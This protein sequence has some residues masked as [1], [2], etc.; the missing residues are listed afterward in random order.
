M[1]LV[2]L[3]VRLGLAIVFVIAGVAKLVDRPGSRQS[4]QAF[5]VP[6]RL[7]PAGA[8]ALPVLEIAFALGLLPAS[9]A[10][11][12]SLGMLA[13][14]VGFIGGIAYNL[15]RGRRPDCHCFGQL[16][17]KPIGNDTLVRNGLLAALAAVV[18]LAGP[19]GSGPSAVAW[20]LDL[21]V[22]T[23]L[24]G[25]AVA[26]LTV[27]CAVEAWFLLQLFQQHGR[28]LKRLETAGLSEPGA[29]PLPAA[30]EAGLPINAPAPTLAL[31]AL[32][33]EVTGLTELLTDHRPAVLLFVDPGCRPCL[34]LLPEAADWRQRYADRFHLVAVSR[35]SVEANR[36]KAR[37]LAH[38]WLQRDR[39][40][41]D[42]Y[43]VSGTPSA[44]LIAPDGRIASQVAG[45]VDQ[46]R[47]LVDTVARH[48]WRAVAGD[49]NRDGA[50]AAGCESLSGDR[51]Q[52]PKSEQPHG[53]IGA[54]APAISARSLDGEPITLTT[55]GGRPTLVLFW[56]P[57]CGFCRRMANDLKAWEDEADP[58]DPRLVVISTGTP[59]ANR[60]L[61]LRSPI[62]LDEGFTL[63]SAYGATGTPS[64]VLVDA[65]GRI[66]SAVIVG[67]PD[68]LALARSQREVALA[69]TGD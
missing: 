35:G 37:G 57:N 39:E 48:D 66:A 24:L 31:K 32:D 30:V 14:L 22:D 27:V 29:A 11:F 47:T 17:S 3:S 2:L 58:R 53:L 64:A 69:P 34:E 8:L 19:A 68:V 62:V 7:I 60:A 5:G 55:P 28:L 63:G 23:L 43:R 38:V 25:A 51:R 16:Y 52:D 10:W 50:D 67:G 46:I 59:D 21:R 44:V 6:A 61:G 56:N 4:L 54:A 15:A 26:V 13:L 40:A 1:D 33:G 42:A 49:R 45:G 41:I 9:T 36:E 20:L 65:E 12:A 18:A